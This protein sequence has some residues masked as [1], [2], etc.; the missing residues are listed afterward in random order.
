MGQ[1][2]K[3][4]KRE[5]PRTIDNDTVTFDEEVEEEIAELNQDFKFEDVDPFK[6]QA[7]WS[8]ASAKKASTRRNIVS[9]QKT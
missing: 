6:A 2:S 3:D 1:K 5:I 4:K 7:A 8:F 9:Y